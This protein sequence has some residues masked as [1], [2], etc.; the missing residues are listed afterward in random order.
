MIFFIVM[1]GERFHLDP[2]IPKEILLSK[3]SLKKIP[4]LVDAA[5]STFDKKDCRPLKLFFQDEARFGRMTNPVCCWSP[6]GFRPTLPMQMVREYTHVYSAVCPTDGESFSLILPYASTEMMSLFLREF[7]EQFKNY[8]IVMDSAAWHKSKSLK[9]FEN[10]RIIYQP[11]YSPEVNPTE[12]LWEHL[13]EKYVSNRFWATLNKLEEVLANALA[14][15]SKM[16][17]Y[18]QSLVGFHWAII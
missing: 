13:R 15:V 8:R 12:H 3:R 10:I 5:T 7:S 4:A 16:K 6:K 1:D 17:N 18:I 2:G 11:S 9:N 14:E